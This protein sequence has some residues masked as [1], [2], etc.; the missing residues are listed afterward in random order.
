[1]IKK[2]FFLIIAVFLVFLIIDYS[3]EKENNEIDFFTYNKNRIKVLTENYKEK[4]SDFIEE[5]KENIKEEVKDEIDSSKSSLWE[6][7]KGI[8]N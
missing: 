8:F 6:R 7:I 5:R 4:A 2:I 1:M 3:Q